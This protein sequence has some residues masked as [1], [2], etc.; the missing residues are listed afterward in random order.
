VPL[1]GAP[2]GVL[3]ASAGRF[4]FGPGVIELEPESVAI[5]PL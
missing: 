3:L 2:S 4:V 5:V 1:T